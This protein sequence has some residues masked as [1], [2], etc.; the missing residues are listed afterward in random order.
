ML[1]N[2]FF[3][4]H[5]YTIKSENEYE[6]EIHVNPDHEIFKGHFP[7]QPVVPGVVSVQIINELL[8][9]HLGVQL[10]MTSARTIKYIAMIDPN[11]N[12]VLHY[13]IQFNNVETDSIKV[14]AQVT[15]EEI[16]FVKFNGTFRQI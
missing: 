1:Q 11:I 2:N 8:S 15:F 13:N 7:G 4:I 16:T 6:Y 14:S 9:E 10:M 5:K 3:T 12:P